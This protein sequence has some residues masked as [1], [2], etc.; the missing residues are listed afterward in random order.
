MDKCPS[1]YIA[2]Y[3]RT[4]DFSNVNNSTCPLEHVLL[5]R[6]IR[7]LRGKQR[8]LI[9]LRRRRDPVTR[10]AHEVRTAAQLLANLRDRQALCQQTRRQALFLV[11][12]R[13]G[14]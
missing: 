2:T 6:S 7:C 9:S 1:Q 14:L 4:P 3:R 11:Q 5:L 13:S 8:G 10:L 12:K